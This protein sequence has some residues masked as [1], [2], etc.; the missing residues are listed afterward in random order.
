M[1]GDDTQSGKKPRGS[2]CLV[3]VVV[4][5]NRLDQLQVTLGRLMDEPPE[6]LA[7]IIV[8]DNA[9]DDGTGAWLDGVTDPRLEICRVSSNLGG[10]GGFSLGVA[11]ARARFDPDWMLLMDDDARPAPG[12]VQSFHAVHRPADKAVAAAVYYPDGRICEMNRPSVN[13][14]WNARS[15]LQTLLLLRGRDG[16]HISP[17]AYEKDTPIPVDL[18]SFVGFFVSRDIVEQVGLPDAKLFL[19]GDDVL[20][21]LRLR[22]AGFEILFDPKIRFEH[23]C[24][25]FEN[26]HRRVFNPIWKVYYAYRNGLLMYQQAAGL[27]FWPLLLLLIPKWWLAARRYGDQRPAYSRLMWRAVRDAVLGRTELSHDEV[28]AL[29]RP[30]N[31]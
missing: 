7:G 1:V 13:P 16:Y 12:G 28:L 25:T 27:L 24:S 19:Y 2:A 3:A 30:V 9:S 26:D 21:A 4:T 6:L 17:A 29:V 5:H 8:V 23:D 11:R 22:K 31:G 18:T 10:S 14:F 15:F 20:Y